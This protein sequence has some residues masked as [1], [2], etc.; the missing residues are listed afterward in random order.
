MERPIQLIH[1]I[2]D[3]FNDQLHPSDIDP[4]LADPIRQRISQI[5]CDYEE[6]NDANLLGKAPRFKIGVGYP[7]LEE[8]PDLARA[9][10]F[11][12]RE[13]AAIS[14][15]LYRLAQVLVDQFMGTYSKV[16]EVIVLDLGH[17]EVDERFFFYYFSHLGWTKVDDSCCASDPA[18]I[19]DRVY[20]FNFG[21]RDS[22]NVL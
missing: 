18:S 19:Q 10:T 14:R 8:D 4:R 22:T 15:N 11:P 7:P 3:A 6:A 9:V 5:A 1:Q 16:A 20:D 21:H 12:G 2:G 17:A 13:N